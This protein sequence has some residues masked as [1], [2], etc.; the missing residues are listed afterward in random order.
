MWLFCARVKPSKTIFLLFSE[1]VSIVQ[2]NI[3][4]KCGKVLT[5]SQKLYL[6]SVFWHENGRTK[7]AE[8]QILMPNLYIISGCNGAGKT[9]ASLTV[10]P[11]TLQ[12]KEFVNCDEIAK[13]LSPLNPDGAK[14][15]AGRLMLSRI[16][17]LI[18][19]KADFA[20][21]T[22]L[23]AKSYHALINKARQEGYKASLIYFW[24]QSPDLAIKR[25]AERVAHGGHH[26]D[27]SIIRRRYKAGIKNL[28]NLYCPVVD[29]FLFIDNSIMP[30]E[31]IAEGNIKAIKFYNEEKF[32]KIRQYDNSNSE[33]QEE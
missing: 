14:V 23:A 33:C 6:C 4:E 17:K 29:Y 26:V 16:K 15:A 31:V 24:L 25:V 27:D 21:E 10:L 3:V 8:I 2:K 12:C 13:G 22:T 5:Y 20:I 30:S 28:F 32:K 18:A 11:E 19:D 1:L 9:T 7:R